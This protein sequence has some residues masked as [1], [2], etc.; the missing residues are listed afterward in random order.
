VYGGMRFVDVQ[1][2]LIGQGKLEYAQRILEKLRAGL[3]NPLDVA[4]D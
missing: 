1:P 2:E 3:I 4:L